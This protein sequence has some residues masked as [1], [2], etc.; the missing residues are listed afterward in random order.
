MMA[1]NVIPSWKVHLLMENQ[2]PQEAIVFENE[3]KKFQKP[4]I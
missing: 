1:I 2:P 3:K 4:E